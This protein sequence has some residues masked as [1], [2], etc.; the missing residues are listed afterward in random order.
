MGWVST[1][2]NLVPAG[3]VS[4][5]G[6]GFAEACKLVWGSG[7]EERLRLILILGQTGEGKKEG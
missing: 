2:A 7:G 4:V 6:F 5:T 3:I 1:R